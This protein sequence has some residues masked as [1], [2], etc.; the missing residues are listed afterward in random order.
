MDEYQQVTVI[1]YTDSP[2]V[3][4]P[5]VNWELGRN[6]GQKKSLFKVNIKQIVNRKELKLIIERPS[7]VDLL[8]LI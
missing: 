8:N 3:P 2:L 5:A 4:F 6:S 1:D 7:G